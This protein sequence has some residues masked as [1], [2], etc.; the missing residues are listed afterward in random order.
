MVRIDHRGLQRN[1]MADKTYLLNYKRFKVWIDTTYPLAGRQIYI[2][3]ENVDEYF[4]QVIVHSRNDPNVVR[5]VVSSLQYFSD[6]VEH[7][8][9]NPPFNVESEVV[10]LALRQQRVAHKGI[11][12]ALDRDPHGL[13]PTN[14]LCIEQIGQLC[15]YLLLNMPLIVLTSFLLCFST[16]IRGEFFRDLPLCLLRTDTSNGP[17]RSDGTRERVFDLILRGKGTKRL[18]KTRVTGCLRHVDVFKCPVGFTFM[19]LCMRLRSQVINF[20]KGD[21][22]GNS[23]WMHVQLQNHWSTYQSMWNRYKLI[24][25]E[26]HWVKKT[27]IKKLGMDHLS[28]VLGPQGIEEVC[29]LSKHSQEK[30]LDTL[31]NS[32]RYV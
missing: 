18:A 5:R 6:H 17:L 11:N 25:E 20:R 3:R 14:I 31:P 2:T 16:L 23:S 22:A 7:P 19:Q 30:S 32:H 24:P 13:I 1:T 29:S 15:E 4:S 9:A 21:R 27:H 10:K 8:T 28:K 12:H 26:F